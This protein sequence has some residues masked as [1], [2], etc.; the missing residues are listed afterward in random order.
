MASR[1]AYWMD[2]EAGTSGQPELRVVSRCAPPRP[3]WGMLY[4]MLGVI[5]ALGVLANVGVHDATALTFLDAGFGSLLFVVLAGW[6][7]VNRVALSRMDEP[8][9]GVGRPGITII[10]SRKP[11]AYDED[12]IT[13]LDPDDRVVVPYDFQ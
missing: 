10:R 6:V 7:H 8:D 11:A 3:R 4:A 1:R 9:A 2:D 13:R 5:G 12:R